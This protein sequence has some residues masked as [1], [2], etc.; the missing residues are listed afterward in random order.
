MVVSYQR[1]HLIIFDIK[2]WIWR[3]KDGV[4]AIIQRPCVRCGRMPMAEGHDAC[5]GTLPGVKHACCGHGV[6]ESITVREGE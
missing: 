4:P 3:Y 2:N 5:L 6:E 1:G